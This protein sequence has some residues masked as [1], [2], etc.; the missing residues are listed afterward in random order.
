M[1][2][3]KYKYKYATFS[4]DNG[5]NIQMTKLFDF[6]LFFIAY[7]SRQEKKNLN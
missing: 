4:L 1:L 6:N 5:A 7:E 3:Y 2:Y